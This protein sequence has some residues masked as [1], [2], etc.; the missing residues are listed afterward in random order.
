MKSAE[1]PRRAEGSLEPVRAALRNANLA[2]H[3]GRVSDL[4]G[5]IIEASGLRA[6][7]GELCLINAGRHRDPVAAEVVGFRK[8]RTMLMPL[9]E[10]QG[11]GPGTK[12]QTTGSTFQIPVG[13]ALLGRVLDGLGRPIDLNLRSRE[14]REELPERDQTLDLQRAA[15]RSTQSS[16]PDP[17]SRPPIRERVALGVRALDALVP[18]GRGQRLGIFAGSGVGKSSLLGMIA[19]ASAASVNVIALVGERGREVGE[20]IERDLG[21]GLARS[22]VVVATSDQPALVRIK[23]AF[24]AT[25]IAEHFR[26]RGHDVLLMMDSITRFAMAQREV[27]L[28]VGEPPATRGYTPSVFALLPRLLERAGRNE[29]GSITGLYT[30]LVDGDDMNEPIADAVRAILDGHIVLSRTLAHAGHYPAIDIL[31]SVSRLADEIVSADVRRAAQRVRSALARM[32]E[33]EDLIAIGAYRSGS[34]PELDAALTLR[35]ELEQ[36]LCQPVAEASSAE[37]AEAQ[38]K[39]LASALEQAMSLAAPAQD[40]EEAEVLEGEALPPAAAL[41]AYAGQSAIPDLRL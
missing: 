23:A 37:Q 20:F 41:G 33:K 30:V 9:G 34:D 28:A 25:A 3:N 40:E 24:T 19:R 35:G 7:V 1:E 10:L 8:G 11:I 2:R 5:L 31:Q 12:V 16:P 4:I 36:F 14:R 22:V 21:E 26:D 39:A 15:L 17:L 27:G 29:K 32:H 38:L 6:E 13:E 18:C